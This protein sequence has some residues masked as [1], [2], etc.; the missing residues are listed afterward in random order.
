[1]EISSIN[2]AGARA[3]TDSSSCPWALIQR[4]TNLC[5]AIWT[6]IGTGCGIAEFAKMITMRA[7][8]AHGRCFTILRILTRESLVDRE[9]GIYITQGGMA[10]IESG[11]S[12][13]TSEVNWVVYRIGFCFPFQFGFVER[14]GEPR[15]STITT[16]FCFFSPADLYPFLFRPGGRR[17]LLVP[18]KFALDTASSACPRGG[19]AES[20]QGPGIAWKLCREVPLITLR[21][22][23]LARGERGE[24]RPFILRMAD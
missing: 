23:A 12:Q 8:R 11:G 17:D 18:L 14:T 13:G 15:H 3:R 10:S 19:V 22:D 16:V 24:L 2:R 7:A 1:M 4:V 9:R 6:P 5:S 20:S 21:T